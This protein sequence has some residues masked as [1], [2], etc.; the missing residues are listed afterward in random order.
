MKTRLVRMLCFVL[1]LV[2]LAGCG[3][4]KL[5]QIQEEGLIVYPGIQWNASPE[6]VLAAL[7][8]EEKDVTV[9]TDIP[10]QAA[11]SDEGY[12]IGQYTFSAEG[13]SLFGGETKVA[14]QF[15]QY[16]EKGLGLQTVLV[17]YPDSADMTKIRGTIEKCLGAPTN[18]QVDSGLYLNLDPGS[19]KGHVVY[20]DS[21][22][23]LGDYLG[24]GD[25]RSDFTATPAVR[26]YWTDD[27]C[28]FYYGGQMENF[29]GQRNL[30]MFE[31]PVAEILQ[32][33]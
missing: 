26:L 6:E 25:G 10:F 23:K 18:D 12:Q 5:P 13:I 4:E 33:G 3:S 32:Q 20:W 8:L 16:T 17:C 22:A 9:E 27:A 15:R 24:N 19:V 31:A 2:L 11:G 21:T 7:K 29:D 14:F 28:L 1:C 30:L